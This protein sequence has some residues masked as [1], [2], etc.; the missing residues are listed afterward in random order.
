MKPQCALRL[1][2]SHTGGGVCFQ[3]DQ[4]YLLFILFVWFQDYRETSGPRQ[5]HVCLSD[6]LSK[7]KVFLLFINSIELCDNTLNVNK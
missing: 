2:C 3:Q 6:D 4:V 5:E 1:S 7:Y